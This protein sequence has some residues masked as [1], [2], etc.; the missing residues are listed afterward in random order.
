[1]AAKTQQRRALDW[2]Q[3]NRDKDE[4]GALRMAGNWSFSSSLL[5][6]RLVRAPATENGRLV[7]ALELSLDRV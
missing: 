1:M 6:P 2:R 3:L 4:L 5:R 7:G